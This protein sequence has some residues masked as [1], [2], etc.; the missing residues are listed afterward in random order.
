VELFHHSPPPPQRLD[1]VCGDKFAMLCKSTLI[2]E[3][4]IKM[5]HKVLSLVP[6]SKKWLLILQ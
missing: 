1:S 4:L 5:A 2:G 6:L 3:T